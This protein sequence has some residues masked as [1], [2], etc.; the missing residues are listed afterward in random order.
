MLVILP[1][2]YVQCSGFQAMCSCKSLWKESSPAAEVPSRSFHTFRQRVA[3]KKTQYSNFFLELSKHML[4][5]YI[6]QLLVQPLS[7]LLTYW[8]LPGRLA[9]GQ[10]VRKSGSSWDSSGLFH[11]SSDKASRVNTIEASCLREVNQMVD[12][13]VCT[14]NI[15]IIWLSVQLRWKKKRHQNGRYLLVVIQHS[16]HVFNPDSINGPIKDNPLSIFWGG[17]SLIPVGG[18][19]DTI[20]PLMADGI[21]AAIQL[22]HGDGLG[23]DDAVVHCKLLHQIG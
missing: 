14:P 15:M 8:Q 3:K 10:Q 12:P 16:I 2:L 19:Q 1:A 4:W 18:G 7:V 22:A 5:V 11:H 9:P 23:V 17:N 21:E 13:L 6:L 20:R